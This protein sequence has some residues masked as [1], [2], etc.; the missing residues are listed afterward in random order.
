MTVSQ[1]LS[2]AIQAS[3]RKSSVKEMIVSLERHPHN[4]FAALRHPAFGAIVFFTISLVI[5]ANGRYAPVG[6]SVPQEFLPITLIREHNFNF[7]EFLDEFTQG[8]G[9]LPY[10]FL[11]KNNHVISFYGIVPGILNVPAFLVADWLGLD[12][13]ANRGRLTKWTTAILSA[14]SVAFMFLVN[15]RVCSN[16]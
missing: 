9:R 8:T 2:P 7:D 6:D 14:M 1:I 13:V 16:R 12:L 15:V 10:F 5:Y 4:F 11:L 3:L